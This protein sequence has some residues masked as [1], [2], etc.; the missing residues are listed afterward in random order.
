M[1]KKDQINRSVASETNTKIRDVETGRFSMLANKSDIYRKMMDI[2]D[3]PYFYKNIAGK[4][5]EEILSIVRRWL[6]QEV[7]VDDKGNTKDCVIVYDYFKLMDQSALENMQEYQALGFQVSKLTD[8]CNVYQIPCIAF[9]QVNREGIVKETS[10]IVSQSD[11]LLWLC[12]SLTLLRRK[13]PEEIAESP[14]DGNTIMRPLDDRY[15]GLEPGDYIN[16]LFHRDKSILIE[17]GTCS[18]ARQRKKDPSGLVGDADDTISDDS[19]T[20]VPFDG[21]ES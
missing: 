7:G 16:F 11:R 6:S 10:D 9:V 18:Q 19:D 15:G 17:L 13:T 2:K 4:P 8:F 3:I 12:G 5:F 14:E 21:P 1:N 20:E